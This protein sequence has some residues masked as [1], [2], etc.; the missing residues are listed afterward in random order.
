MGIKYQ[1]IKNIPKYEGI[2]VYRI[3][4]PINGKV[5]IGSSINCYNRLKRHNRSLPNLLMENDFPECG[6]DCEILE[7]FENGCTNR[8]LALTEQKYIEE[9]ER[10]ESGVYNDKCHRAIHCQR[11]GD[12]DDFITAKQNESGKRTKAYDRVSLT[13]YK[14]GKDIFSEH[15]K[16]RGESLNSFIQRAIRETIERDMQEVGQ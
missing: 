4:N 2:G 6:Y 14:G 10:K 8:Q 11:R 12:I 9:Y 3:I 15:A 7:R 5:Y 13:L 16:K 1:R